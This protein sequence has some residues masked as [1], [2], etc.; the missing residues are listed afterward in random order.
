[1]TFQATQEEDHLT[2]FAFSLLALS[3]PEVQVL[4]EE[5]S[6]GHSPS[7]HSALT[8]LLPCTDSSHTPHLQHFEKLRGKLTKNFNKI[9]QQ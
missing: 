6:W 9:F 3:D 4:V 1:M 7:S 2:H 5:F 8:P